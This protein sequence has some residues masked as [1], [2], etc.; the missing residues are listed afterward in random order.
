MNLVQ[1]LR[2]KFTGALCDLVRMSEGKEP[3]KQRCWRCDAGIPRTGDGFHEKRSG[4]Y[5]MCS[6]PTVGACG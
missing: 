1:Y 4:V 5:A 6:R 3:P 2:G